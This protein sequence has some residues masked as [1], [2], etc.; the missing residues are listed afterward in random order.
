LIEKVAYFPVLLFT[1]APGNEYLRSD[2][3]TESCHEYYHV[4][5]TCNG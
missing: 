2:T 5:D 1:V 3:E 4:E